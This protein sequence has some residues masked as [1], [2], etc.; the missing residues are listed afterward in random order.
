MP[1]AATAHHVVQQAIGRGH[2]DTDFAVLL[3]EQA[4]ASALALVPE[5]VAV[6]DGLDAAAAAG[7]Q[8]SEWGN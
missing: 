5:D 7:G 2:T 8:E 3:L 1:V 4:A 6:S